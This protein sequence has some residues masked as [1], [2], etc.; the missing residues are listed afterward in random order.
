MF[1]Y[2]YQ[3]NKIFEKFNVAKKTG[4]IYK[5]VRLSKIQFYCIDF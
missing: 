3:K 5:I 2:L 4:V 1:I